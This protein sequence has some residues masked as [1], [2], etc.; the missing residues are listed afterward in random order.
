[1]T[2]PLS[3]IRSSHSH[4]EVDAE[5][6]E[7]LLLA[8]SRCNFYNFLSRLF[9]EEVSPK[10][11]EQLRGPEFGEIFQSVGI[12]LS[13]QTLSGESVELLEELAAAYCEMFLLG[14][15]AGLQPFESVQLEARLQGDTTEAVEIFYREYGL[16]VE[17]ANRTLPDHLGIELSFMGK[18]ARK[19]AACW[20]QGDHEGAQEA[21]EGQRRFLKDHLFRWVP[22]Y[23]K[24][25]ERN[26]SHPIYKDTGALAYALMELEAD[27][28]ALDWKRG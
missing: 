4:A 11:L 14:N 6:D 8:E 7:G 20:E 12:T 23:S 24:S 1:M 26:A 9:I 16:E 21:F 19:E 5:L 17:E 15:V 25:L 28:F 18:L 13:S 22:R 27:V 3:E 2:N 10:F